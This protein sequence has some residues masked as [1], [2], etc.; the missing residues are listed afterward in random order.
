MKKVFFITIRDNAVIEG[1]IVENNNP[2]P[3]NEI[4]TENGKMY[5]PKNEMLWHDKNELMVN[6]F[7]TMYRI[8]GLN[9]MML[10]YTL[11]KEEAEKYL[12]LAMDRFPEKFI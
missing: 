2:S 7:V 11:T 12:E 10:R 5:V 8:L 3:V 4:I 1:R 9:N 6:E